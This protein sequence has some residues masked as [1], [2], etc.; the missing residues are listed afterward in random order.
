M[1]RINGPK[2]SGLLGKGWFHGIQH[3][4]SLARPSSHLALRLAFVALLALGAVLVLSRPA[5]QMIGL[6]PQ[7][8][9]PLV[10]TQY[11]LENPTAGIGDQD[12]DAAALKRFYQARGSRLAWSGSPQARSAAQLARQALSRGE[13]HGLDVS[14]YHLERLAAADTDATSFDLLMTDALLRYARELRSG[15]IAPSAAYNDIALPSQ[16]FD[17]ATALEAALSS[18]TFAEFLAELVPL[19]PEYA[20]LMSALAKYR[21]I[22]AEGNWAPLPDLPKSVKKNDPDPR[23]AS[24]PARLAREGIEV[25]PE[26][27]TV[28][29]LKRYQSLNGLDP[30]GKLGQQTLAMLNVQPSQRVAQIEANM[31]RWRWLPRVF[32][33]RYVTINAADA[34]LEL[35]D[36]GEILLRSR[37]IVGASDKRTPIMRTVAREVTANPPW[38]VPTSIA[39]NEILPKLRRDANYLVS[40]RMIL[41]NG[42]PDDPQG[43]RIDWKKIPAGTFPY[44]I[45][46]R[47]G[48]DNALGTLKLEMPNDFNVYLHDTPGRSAFARPNRT[49][50]HGCIRVQEIMSL[51]SVALSGD[52]LSAVGELKEAIAAGVT[53]RIPLKAPLAVYVLYWT[54]LSDADGTVQFRPDVYGRDRQL[55]A[56]LPPKTP[57]SQAFLHEDCNISAG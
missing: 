8:N 10:L 28:A 41:V 33:S 21:Q 44:R 39:R 13:A 36:K 30:D 22:A 35:I 11:S 24:L 49:L 20:R 7:A 1:T 5:A 53:K 14:H 56:A 37:V 4:T 29:A 15:R 16:A 48:S 17:A 40:Q 50:S 2:V 26:A 47:P 57:A 43:T 46:Q 54:A 18:G 45:Q 51:A 6:S 19:H 3:V 34:T 42:P 32:E 12:V 25:A 55:L 9:A 31:E 52:A 38:N 27:D 23:L